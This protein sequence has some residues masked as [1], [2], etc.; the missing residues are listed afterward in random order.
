M[1]HRPGKI[2]R[3][4]LARWCGWRTVVVLSLLGGTVSC[5]GLGGKYFWIFDLF[6]NFQAQYCGFQA[7]CLLVFLGLRRFRW[8][9]LPTLF[10][11]LPCWRLAPYF[12]PHDDGPSLPR[13]LRVLSFNVL[14][15]NT[16]YAD[17]LRWVQQTDPDIAFFPEVTS[18]WADGLSPL[19]ARMPHCILRPQ[20]HNFGFALFSKYPIVGHVLVPSA[21]LG[22]SMVQVTL[23]LHGQQMVFFGMH[24]PSPLSADFSQARDDAFADL[25]TRLKNETRPVIVA[26][27]FNATP[28]SHSARPLLEAGLRDSMLGRGFSATWQ[29]HIPLLA[30]P[31]D[32]ILLGGPIVTQARWTGPDL[33]SDHRPVVADLRW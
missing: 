13:P 5:L 10:L 19:K 29:H 31:I 14:F 26:G 1:D 20:S 15:T 12:L 32:R 21:V 3:T 16:R 9:L 7:L 23:D 17:T 30:I 18:L 2:L 27:D 6:N 4:A 33:G 11:I 25:T 22:I 24:P 8:A 28:W